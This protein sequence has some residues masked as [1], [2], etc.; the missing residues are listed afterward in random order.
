MHWSLLSVASLLW[1][2]LHVVADDD[3]KKNVP[4]V[5]NHTCPGSAWVSNP[6]GFRFS[7]AQNAQTHIDRTFIDGFNMPYVFHPHDMLTEG[8]TLFV[9][10]KVEK[11]CHDFSVNF[12]A[13]TPLV[14]SAFTDGGVPLHVT[15]NF[16][17]SY[18]II[19]SVKDGR[20]M[21]RGPH[22]F[23]NPFVK[24]EKFD[25][26]VHMFKDYNEIVVNGRKVFDS[27]HFLPLDVV[28]FISVVGDVELTSIR[29][30]GHRFPV[31]YKKRLPANRFGL[32]DRLIL[33]ARSI[34][35][36]FNV[37]FLN[38]KEDITLFFN[39]NF[40]RKTVTRN[41]LINGRWGTEET[42]G[43]FPFEANVEFTLEIAY[44]AHG[45]L[46]IVNHREFATFFHRAN[47]PSTDY[48]FIELTENIQA[49]MLEVCN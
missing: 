32:N 45:L 21:N 7:S 48:T 37:N 13:A 30:E 19:D 1:I 35:G 27:K 38:E 9:E 6:T 22:K 15:I 26:R 2:A 33:I 40:D 3:W 31:P 28:D 18:L 36:N 24:G 16:D 10:G 12:M 4:F 42:E 43:G 44:K 23:A 34:G 5:G 39:V 17:R 25:I 11:F 47:T 46:L 20:W 29:V 14:L 41:S 8:Q 49:F